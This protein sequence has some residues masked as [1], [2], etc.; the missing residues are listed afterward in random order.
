MDWLSEKQLAGAV[1]DALTASICVV[2]R[3]GVIVAVNEAWR[4]FAAE[5]GGNKSFLGTNYLDVCRRAVGNGANDAHRFGQ[6]IQEVLSGKLKRFEAEYPCHSQHEQ[7]WFLA[8]VTPIIGANEED[9]GRAA[10]ITHQDITARKR[11][12][13]ELK[14][15]A[16]TDDL[17]GL[18]N[19]RR[20]F[21]SA[22][23]VLTRVKRDSAPAS[24]FVVDLDHFKCIN[25]THGHAAGDEALCHTARQLALALRR[26]DVLAR[27]GGEEFGVLLPN[28]D[29][30]GA[31]MLAERV[32]EAIADSRP[33]VG[34]G[35]ISLTASIGVASFSRTDATPDAALDR[36]DK[37]LYRAKNDGRNLVRTST[38][39]RMAVNV[40]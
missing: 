33:N 1:L 38:L 7:R 27:I 36:A 17:T 4:H 2:D 35:Q 34:A 14:R 29:E 11:L 22:A 39:N 28:T 25:D 12:E 6:R 31:T 21:E 13:F 15:L 26:S 23:K 18:K 20:F 10:V 40:A 37:A 5:N 24:L 3:H 8:R 16:E 32:R 19:R 9:P 30:W